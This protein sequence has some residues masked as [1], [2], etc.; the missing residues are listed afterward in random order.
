MRK[1]VASIKTTV[2]KEHRINLELSLEQAIWL[3]CLTGQVAFNAEAIRNINDPIFTALDETIDNDSTCIRNHDHE[4][5]DARQFNPVILQ[6]KVEEL[7]RK[8]DNDE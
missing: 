2:V 5:T 7:R 1:P 8:L 4:G 3:H 6:E